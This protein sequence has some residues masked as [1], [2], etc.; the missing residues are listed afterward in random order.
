AAHDAEIVELGVRELD[1]PFDEVMPADRALFR[2]AEADHRWPPGGRHQPAR[3]GA[4]GTPAAVVARLLAARALLGAKLIQLLLRRPAAIRMAGGDELLSDLLVAREPLHLEER[5]L[6]PV[7]AKPAH[8][9]DDCR[10]RGLR[11]AVEVGGLHPQ[12]AP[13]G[14]A[15]RRGPGEEA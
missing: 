9:V 2:R 5:T 8:A 13:A 14:R 11:G 10:H 3:L 6:V 7:D 4:L 1:R 15:A 12:D